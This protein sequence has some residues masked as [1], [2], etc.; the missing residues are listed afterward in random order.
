MK[1]KAY[2]DKNILAEHK[3]TLEFTKDDYVTKEGDCIVGIKADYSLEELKKLK[4]EKIK[5]IISCNGQK[6][7]LIGFRNKSFNDDREMVVRLGTYIC[8]RTFLFN[9]DKS[10]KYLSRELVNEIK[11]GQEIIIEVNCYEETAK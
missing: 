8:P 10:A 11:K 4:C 3:T 9:A 2:G 7:E 6:D 1:F 5:M